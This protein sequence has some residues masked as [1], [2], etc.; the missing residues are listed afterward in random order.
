[1]VILKK[2]MV[3]NFEAVYKYHPQGK[4]DFGIVSVHID[5]EKLR[6][7]KLDNDA[8]HSYLMHAY[9]RICRMIHENDYPDEVTVLWY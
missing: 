4:E 5:G 6:P 3:N 2:I 8:T 1:M 9:K 7:K